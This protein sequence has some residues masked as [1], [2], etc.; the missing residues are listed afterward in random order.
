MNHKKG[1]TFAAI[2][3]VLWGFVAIGVKIV[4]TEVDVM[5]VVWLRMLIAALCLGGYFLIKQPSYLNIY[6]KPP[7]LIWLPAIGLALNYVW[8]VSGIELA[9]AS[10]TQVIIQT[11]PIILCLTGF[12]FF[13]ERITKTQMFGFILAFVGLIFFYQKQLSS[14]NT[15]QD[16]FIKGV[17]LT[18]AAAIAWSFYSISQKN[19]VKTYPVQQINLFIYSFAAVVYTPFVDF[20]VLGEIPAWAWLILILL[21]VTT[22]AAYG[23]MGEALKYTDASRISVIVILNPILTFIILELMQYFNVTNVT[24]T[25]VPFLAYVGAALMMIGAVLANIGGKKK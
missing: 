9:G 11:G 8:F 21:G 20:S 24:F 13:K 4:L 25:S 22:V 1:S 10:A 17:L 19:L 5:T 16:Q 7:R 14:M 18:F 3:A 23:F 12:I 2:T 6:I 15:G